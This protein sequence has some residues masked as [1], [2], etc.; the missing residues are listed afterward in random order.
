MANIS[1]QEWPEMTLEEGWAKA[2]EVTLRDITR[3]S[4]KPKELNNI[5]DLLFSYLLLLFSS[6]TATQ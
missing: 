1:I 2:F 5:G 4:S 3:L 6:V